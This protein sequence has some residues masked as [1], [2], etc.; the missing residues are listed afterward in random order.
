MLTGLLLAAL[1]FIGCASKTG[2]TTPA[3]PKV[4]C[5]GGA[6]SF[7]C[8]AYV[9]LDTTQAAIEQAKVGVPA[10][11][12]ALLNQVIADYNLAKNLY[13]TYHAAA[14]AGTATAADQATLQAKMNSIDT[15]VAALGAK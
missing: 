7:D 9:W 4:V 13:L 2:A 11:K 5:A 14:A 15:N 3:T 10:S 8:T 1:S 12:K 6:N